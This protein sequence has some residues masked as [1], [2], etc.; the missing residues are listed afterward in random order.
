MDERQT[1]LFLS[2]WQVLDL[3]SSSEDEITNIDEATKESFKILI[4]GTSEDSSHL[5]SITVITYFNLQEQHKTKHA[6]APNTSQI[7][8][9]KYFHMSAT[10]KKNC[11]IR[12]NQTK[13][14]ISMTCQLRNKLQAINI[15]QFILGVS[16]MKLYRLIMVQS[17]ITIGHEENRKDWQSWSILLGS[18][19]MYK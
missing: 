8:K 17:N 13:Y 9:S 1:E 4:N 19:K 7:L 10:C 5:T 12:H 2:L 6:L 3:S 14:L 11:F 18:C 16:I 15:F